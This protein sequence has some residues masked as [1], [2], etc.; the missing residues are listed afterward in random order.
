M[1]S[2]HIILVARNTETGELRLPLD[3]L[4]LYGC[5]GEDEVLET[6]RQT[7]GL[8]PE[9]VLTLYAPMWLPVVGLDPKEEDS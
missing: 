2:S 9:W 3:N 4:T 5:G 1:S 8:G 7:C 6:T